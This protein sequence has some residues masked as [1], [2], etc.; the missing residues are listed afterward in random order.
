MLIYLPACASASD[1]PLAVSEDARS[2]LREVATPIPGLQVASQAIVV[3]CLRKKGYGISPAPRRY[4]GQTVSMLGFIGLFRTPEEAARYGYGTT[5]RGSPEAMTDAFQATLSAQDSAA[6]AVDLLGDPS[7][8]VSVTTISGATATQT[9]GGCQG[10]ADTVLFG[11]TE[12][13]LTVFGLQN[14]ILALASTWKVSRAFD[15]AMPAYEK[16]MADH[17]L[18]VK[19]MN[20]PT[21][22]VDRFKVYRQMGDPPSK[23]ESG[24]AEVD[25]RC[26]EKAQLSARADTAFYSVAASWVR[27]HRV[28]L[29]RAARQVKKAKVAVAKALAAEQ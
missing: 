19:G 23:A 10:E 6:F 25:A 1:Q 2:D 16:C 18:G 12:N 21:L 11:S 27:Q 26:Q 3:E 17:G 4:H 24:M 29:R 13:Q 5:V 20:A 15:E 8:T 9:I 22:A 14:D 28:E 7:K